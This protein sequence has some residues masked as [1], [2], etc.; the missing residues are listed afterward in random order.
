MYS[1]YVLNCWWFYILQ[2]LQQDTVILPR[3]I[4]ILHN[5]TPKEVLNFP[6]DKMQLS[7]SD[8]MVH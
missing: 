3:M 1:H 7:V 4:D 8:G 5:L 2:H 6:V